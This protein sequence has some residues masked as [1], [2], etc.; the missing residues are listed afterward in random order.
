MSSVTL[1]GLPLVVAEIVVYWVFA[2][3]SWQYQGRASE[4]RRAFWGVC[5]K[6]VEVTAKDVATAAALSGQLSYEKLLF[7]SKLVVAF[8]IADVI[9]SAIML[10]LLLST[11]ALLARKAAL[12]PAPPP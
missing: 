8:K 10:F 7:Y 11:L 3:L 1:A 4:L 6:A 9:A 5:V 12:K 2:I